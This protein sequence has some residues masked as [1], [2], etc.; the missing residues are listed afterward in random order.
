MGTKTGEP[1]ESFGVG[2]TNGILLP[3]GETSNRHRVRLY[4][5]HQFVIK[6]KT[7]DWVDPAVSLKV[8]EIF[9]VA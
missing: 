3:F 6:A 4:L 9:R 7:E 1:Q 2:W 5:D 8:Q